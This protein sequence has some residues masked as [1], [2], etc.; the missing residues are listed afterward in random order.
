[1][2]GQLGC[3]GLQLPD[4]D[5]HLVHTSP[6]AVDEPAAERLLSAN[7]IFATLA[8]FFNSFG[9]QMMNTTLPVYVLSIG[10]TQAQ[11]GLVGGVLPL[12][13]L[14][15]R[16]LMGW[17]TD[18]WKRRRLAVFGSS[19]YGLASIVY[20][21]SR[22][23]GTLF[24]GRVI[25]GVGISSYTT[26]A[27][28]YIADIA[29][30]KRR[31]E[32][33][34]LF[35]VTTSLGLIVGPSVGFYIVSLF[36][37]HWLFNFATGLAVITC[38]VSLFAR[39]KRRPREGQRQAWSPRTGIV[40]IDAL[41]MAWTALCLGLAAGSVSNFIAIFASSRGVDNPGLYFSVQAVALLISRAFS[42]RLADR[43][44]RPAAIIPG[45]ITMSMALAT[46][47]LAH[48]LPHFLVTAALFGLGFGTAQPAT[49]ALLID[50]VR[51]EQQGLGVATYYMGFDV[52]I[53]LGAAASG[54]VSQAWG[55]GVMWPLAA[56]F[57]LLGLMGLIGASR[58]R[59]SDSE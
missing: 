42:G 15:L 27:N 13:A 41:P 22:S 20:A 16:P 24:L 48:D 31:A 55:F 58:G 25:H 56:A 17:A 51:P 28:A 52:G 49:M 19:C 14:L 12:T 53:F 21:L 43:H 35:A 9:S 23:I 29:P 2:A 1:M 32:A 47:P 6:G 59:A 4:I 54:V 33:M 46:L 37:F 10:G 40:A 5:Q 3:K 38:I 36:D 30:S 57:T 45:A 11:A 18:A 8:N 26:A 7:F 39:E 44:G 50:Q 34:G